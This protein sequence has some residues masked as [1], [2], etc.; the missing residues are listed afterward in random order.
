MRSSTSWQ[1]SWYAYG[2]ELEC[3]HCGQEHADKDEAEDCVAI[4]EDDCLC[5]ECSASITPEQAVKW[6]FRCAKCG[7][8][9]AYLV[10]DIERNKEGGIK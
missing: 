6:S 3:K 10:S 2:Y 9:G 5:R 8:N 1:G 7:E 4:H